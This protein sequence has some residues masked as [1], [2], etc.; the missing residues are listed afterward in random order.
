MDDKDIPED[1][2]LLRLL[3]LAGVDPQQYQEVLKTMKSGIKVVL[4]RQPSERWINQYN[5]AILKT[6]R[7]NMD[8]QFI[9][10]PYSCIMYI[11]SYMMKSER[12]M[13]ELLRNVAEENRGEDLKAKLR[14]I[15]SS[16][17]N[18]REVSL[19]ESAYRILSMPLKR[20]SRIV[21]FVNTAPKEKRVSIL[22]SQKQLQEMDDD[23]EN[24]FYKS[25]LDR[26]AARPNSLENMSLAEF[27]ATY[28]SGRMNGPE[29]EIDHIP[30]ELEGSD[31]NDIGGNN[32]DNEYPKVITL[33]NELGQM[34]KRK[35]HCIIRF[36][37]EK[38]EGEEKYR[39]LL[40]LYYPWRS[41][42]ID[43]KGEFASFKEHYEHV[44]ATVHANESKFSFNV[45]ELDRAF[46]DLQRNGPPE[47]AWDDV[48]PNVEFQQAEQE[49]EGMVQ[50]RE[51][52]EED[53]FQNIDLDPQSS[54]R[55][56]ELHNRFKAELD[57]TLMN[58]QE[59]RAMMRS[60]N[61]KQREIIRIHRK[62]CKDSII[63]LKNKQTV[64]Q[65]TIF[66]SGP[67]GVGKS[68]VIKII[69]YETMKLL[70]P[71][72][73][74]FMPDELPVL[75]TAFTGT[76]A[77][78]IEGMTLHSALGL[79]CGPQ[80]KEYKPLSNDRLHTFR[81]RLGKL[82]LL[83]IDEVSMV[84]A[85]LLYD[86]H[87]RLQEITGNL[88]SRFGG[89]SI[90]A[91][92]DLF[93][94]Q[95]VGQQYIFED[96]SDIKTKLHNTVF[97]SLWKENFKLIELEESMRQKEDQQFAQLLMRV[98]KASCTQKDISLLRSRIVKKSDNNYPTEA[99]HVFKTNMEVDAHNAE[100]LQKLST[101]SV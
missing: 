55:H 58:P 82:K 83:I 24:V 18:N 98:R 25:P 9:M 36:H 4:K 33:R 65:Y 97:G 37:K 90:L 63:A 41:E 85:D 12:A 29:E 75:L 28:T 49:A 26:Y 101:H 17:L 43:L 99:L 48:A 70:K 84:G 53:Q 11:T 1:I 62:W 8:L 72:S 71:L 13:G 76:A 40:M 22:K 64:P 80:K 21:V 14:T 45:E 23:D 77:F 66:L 95:P 7:A 59:Y 81:T 5:P 31:D 74:H 96:P 78:G 2:S 88:N 27:S 94:L 38:K 35:R 6:W 50:E 47:D 30:D 73:G 51:L 39:N 46:D 44:K 10:D 69:H 67:G 86:V 68:H 87:R 56:H 42:T 15:G 91:V 34:R 3:Q 100:H 16:F 32:S 20:S 54:S 92:G 52:P 60:L 61:R 79:S 57:K 93:Q 19:Q 89:V